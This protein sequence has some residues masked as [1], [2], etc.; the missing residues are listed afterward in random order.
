MCSTSSAIKRSMCDPPHEQI[1]DGMVAAPQ[2]VL[3]GQHSLVGHPL[4]QQLEGSLKVLAGQWLAIRAGLACSKLTV[5]T[6]H[7]LVGYARP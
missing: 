7:A 5:G 6:R 3:N 1:V 2:D 4:R